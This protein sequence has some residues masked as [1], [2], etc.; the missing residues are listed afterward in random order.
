VGISENV[1]NCDKYNANPH[2]FGALV[3]MM[4]GQKANTLVPKVTSL[5]NNIPEIHAVLYPKART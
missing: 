4:R 2:P 3:R 1:I 5:A